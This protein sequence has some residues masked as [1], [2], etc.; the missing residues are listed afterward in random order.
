MVVSTLQMY[1]M[2]R[3]NKLINIETGNNSFNKFLGKI[4]TQWPLNLILSI[5]HFKNKSSEPIK[6]EAIRN[7]E[8][9]EKKAELKVF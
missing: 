9:K 7:K 5:Q 3:D 8:S 4:F 6:E 2:G 1:S